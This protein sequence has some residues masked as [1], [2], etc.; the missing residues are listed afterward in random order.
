[1]ANLLLR[2]AEIQGQIDSAQVA[3]K[4]GRDPSAV[5]ALLAEFSNR[6]ESED[7]R[8]A[9]ANLPEAL[10]PLLLEEQKLRQSY[11]PDHPEVLAVR[12]KLATT[13]DFFTRPGA[14]YAPAG[15]PGKK[16]T[17]P[18]PRDSVEQHLDVLR[19]KLENVKG[20]D[21]LL[22]G[23]FDSQQEEARKYTSY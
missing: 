11:G 16:R 9:K 13:R 22:A 19:Q 7:A 21:Q 6:T 17:P 20:T 15:E 4:Q 8:A 2:Q 10:Y 23:M 18:G 5:L 12:E 1:R 14:A 3:L